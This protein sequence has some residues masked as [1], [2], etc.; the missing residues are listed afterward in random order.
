MGA[1]PATAGGGKAADAQITAKVN[2]GIAQDRELHGLKIDVDTQD[3]VVTLSGSVPTAA[4]RARAGE[5]AHGVKDVRSVNDQLTL[6][7]G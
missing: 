6:A 1:A 4:S 2:A 7:G 5:I 3:G